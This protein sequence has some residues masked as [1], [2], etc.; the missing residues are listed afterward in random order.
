MQKALMV[1]AVSAGASFAAASQFCV[2]NP[3]IGANSQPMLA[4]DSA[5]QSTTPLQHVSIPAPGSAVVAMA[6]LVMLAR[7]RRDR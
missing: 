2:H 1:L 4:V 7:R 6:G 5:D 3:G